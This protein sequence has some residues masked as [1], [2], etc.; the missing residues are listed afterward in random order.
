MSMTA[1]VE[2][3]T[4]DVA[5]R[6][7]EKNHSNRPANQRHLTD[8]MARQKR[9]EWVPNGDSIRFDSDGY[10]RDGQHRL[11]MVIMSEIPIETVV[12]RDISPSAFVTIDTGKGRNLAD[13]LAIEDYENSTLLAG[14]VRYLRTYVSRIRGVSFFSHE[15]QVS[16]LKKHKDIVASTEFYLGLDI[17]SGAP[18]YKSLMVTW[19]YLFSRVSPEGS[20]DFIERLVTGLRLD[21]SGDPVHRLRGQLVAN[22]MARVP[23][24]LYFV[25]GVGIL[26]WNA[27]QQGREVKAAY[28]LPKTLPA[29]TGFPKELMEVAG[30]QMELVEQ[31]EET[32]G[33]GS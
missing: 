24:Q 27:K 31:E 9:G 14:A 10:L 23:A 1:T 20:N 33:N 11:K 7:L 16:L 2:T 17:P 15:Q 3:I 21:N 32:N 30:R 29:I 25:F 18:K 12:V 5:L 22:Q 4:K 13:V 28:R 26:A 8:L 6:Y 19:H